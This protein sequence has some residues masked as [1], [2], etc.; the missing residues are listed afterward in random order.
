[1]PH[2]AAAQVQ[3]EVHHCTRLRKAE[4]RNQFR[5]SLAEKLREI[6]PR[7]SSEDTMD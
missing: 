2:L 7:L 6:E 1:M 3:K 4:V 5:C